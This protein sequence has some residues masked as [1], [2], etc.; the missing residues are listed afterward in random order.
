MVVSLETARLL[1]ECFYWY[2][3]AIL[4]LSRCAS[5]ESANRSWLSSYSLNVRD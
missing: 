5:A 3:D 4:A 2:D 1:L